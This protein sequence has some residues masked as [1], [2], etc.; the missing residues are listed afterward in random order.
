[1]YQL[2]GLQAKHA[3][4]HEHEHEHEHSDTDACK[5]LTFVVFYS[6]SS[7]KVKKSWTNYKL[8]IS[9]LSFSIPQTGPMYQLMGL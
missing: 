8:D 9:L 4:E 3:H 2:Y 5:R 1:M 6:L 7:W